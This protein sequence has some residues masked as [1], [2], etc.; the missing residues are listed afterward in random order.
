M[1][2][3]VSAGLN[4]AQRPLLRY[5]AVSG[6]IDFMS[7]FHFHMDSGITVSPY[8]LWY[9]VTGRFG[10]GKTLILTPSYCSAIVFIMGFI[11]NKSIEL[12]KVINKAGLM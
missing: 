7:G 9:R 5:S 10:K 6:P 11:K 4:A 1:R 2:S 3:R 12:K 8:K